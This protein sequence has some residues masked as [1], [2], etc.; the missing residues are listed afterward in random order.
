MSIL[1]IAEHDN[2]I[3]KSITLNTIG[4]AKKIGPQY[5]ID[6]LVVGYQCE[7]IAECVSK[8]DGI[9]K[10]LLFDDIVY[11]HNIAE[12]F[13]VLVHTLVHDYTHILCTTSTHGKNFMPRVAALN[14]VTQ[15][16]DVIDIINNNTFIRPIYAGNA[17]ETVE[18][19]DTLKVLTIRATN[20]NP[21]TDKS[22]NPALIQSLS[23]IVTR[24]K[25]SFISHDKSNS[26]RRDITNSDIVI[27]GGRGMGSCE[28]FKLLIPIANKLNAAIGASRA[29]VDAGFAS[30]DC[31]IGQT[32]KVIAP[33][34]YIAIGISGAIQ[35][36]AGI[37]DSNIIVAINKD[38]DA[39]IFSIADY[40]LVADIFEVLPILQDLLN[41]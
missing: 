5:S 15:I 28:K 17:L 37:K 24:Y 10:V 20:F 32:G 19:L 21:I 7:Y 13:S 4:A 12:N 8:I 18:V 9:S 25:S 34:L 22:S 14:N 27:S 6:V 31:Q 26:N 1:V 2:N 35:H 30:N 16:S 33:K 3:L 38:P 40:G 39:Q 23:T 29:A 11:K 41:I 36:I